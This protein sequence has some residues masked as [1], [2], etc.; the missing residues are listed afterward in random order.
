MTA[1]LQKKHD[2]SIEG[3]QN[4]TPTLIFSNGFGTDK[5]AWEVVKQAFKD[6]YRLILYDNVGGGKADPNAFSPIKY[7]KLNTYADDLIALATELE[8]SNAIMIAHSVSSMIAMLA[9]VKAPELFAKLVFV[10]ASPRYLN[11][12]SEDYFGGFDQ[13]DLDNIYT[14]MTTNYYAWVSGFSSAAMANPEKPELGEY[15]AG[16]LAEIRP[17]IAIAVAKV[18]F[19]SDV[20]Q[21]LQKFQK[22]TL[23]LQSHNDIAVPPAVAHYLHKN[24]EGS[25]L[26]FVNSNGH[27]PHISAPKEIISSIKAFI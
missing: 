17:D 26:T 12:E 5:T 21:E 27:F 8:L 4:A 11:D 23:L 18:I 6:D 24:I 9:C 19:E 3:N 22:E 13:P 14:A 25:R 7:N 1:Q 2:I 10:G 16:T 20:R 15:F